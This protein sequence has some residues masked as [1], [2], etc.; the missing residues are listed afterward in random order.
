MINLD[1]CNKEY[2]LSLLVCVTQHASSINSSLQTPWNLS[3]QSNSRN[4]LLYTGR[5][6]EIWIEE[7]I[8]G[9]RRKKTVVCLFSLFHMDHIWASWI[10]EGGPQTFRVIEI[11]WVS[12]SVNHPVMSNSVTPWIVAHQAPLSME[13]SRQENGVSSQSLLQVIFPTR[14]SNLGLLHCRHILFTTW[15]TREVV[16]K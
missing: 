13:F 9:K 4:I 3:L 15:A 1:N 5:W 14:G 7:S 6:K 12:E 16:F 11:L 2:V 8:W 10:E